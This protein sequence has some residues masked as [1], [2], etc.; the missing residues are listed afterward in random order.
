MNKENQREQ[1]KEKKGSQS[2]NKSESD[3]IT[4]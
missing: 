2:V 4:W 3:L 1:K